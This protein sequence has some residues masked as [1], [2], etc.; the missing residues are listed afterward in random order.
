MHHYF[1]QLSTLLMEIDAI[2]NARPLTYVQDDMDG[3]AYTV[4]L[5]I[6]GIYFEVSSTYEALTRKVQNHRHLLSQFTTQ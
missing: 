1:D 5:L 2:L 6:T 4:C 3:A